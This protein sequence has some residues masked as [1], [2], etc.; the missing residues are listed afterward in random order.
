MQK[1]KV[2]GTVKHERAGEGEG[3]RE[4]RERERA[5][6][7]EREGTGAKKE[8]KRVNVREKKKKFGMYQTLFLGHVKCALAG[9]LPAASCGKTDSWYS[10]ALTL[11]FC[12][13]SA[14]NYWMALETY[15]NG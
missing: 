3:G 4:G 7:R 6:E 13:V 15:H 2:G 9:C 8:C 14:C 5:R 12:Y 1:K 11:I 10:L